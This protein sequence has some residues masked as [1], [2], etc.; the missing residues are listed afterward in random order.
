M[1]NYIPS[2]GAIERTNTSFYSSEEMDKK[3]KIIEK[4]E[5]RLTKLEARIK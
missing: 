5:A 1:L 4:L 3:L 2:T